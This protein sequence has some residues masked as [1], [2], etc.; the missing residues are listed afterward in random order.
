MTSFQL[1]GLDDSVPAQL[2]VIGLLD[3]L[4]QSVSAKVSPTNFRKVK[5]VLRLTASQPKFV[6]FL[7]ASVEDITAL[8]VKNDMDL[9]PEGIPKD[10]VLRRWAHVLGHVSQAARFFDGRRVS[11]G[12]VVI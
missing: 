3:S 6:L 7:H 11:F 9:L 10:F 2:E 4:T 8:L 5:E 12:A 1:W